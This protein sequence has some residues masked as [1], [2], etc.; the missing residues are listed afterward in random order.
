[1]DGMSPTAEPD[2]VHTLPRRKFTGADVERMIETGI[3]TDEDR[4]ELIGGDLI[5]MGKQ[6][7]PHWRSVARIVAWIQRR[8]PPHL[9]V[10]SQGPLRLAPFEEPEPDGFIYPDA[11]DV[12]DV[13][14]PDTLLVIEVADSSLI[15][16][17]KIKAPQYARHGVREYWI[18]DISSRVTL[19]HRLIDEIYAK[20]TP[21]PFTAELTVPAIPEPLV[22][23][24]PV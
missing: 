4:V 14:G 19:V 13:K 22:L 1:M 18:V 21:I 10:A 15:K 6:G 9:I 8:L 16:D 7:K 5:D 2:L 11:M 17:T 3:L 24:K 20:P 23:D 12:N